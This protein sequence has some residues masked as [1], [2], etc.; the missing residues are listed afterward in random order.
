[1][2]WPDLSSPLGATAQLASHWL[3]EAPGLIFPTPRSQVLSLQ[4][5]VPR[6]V[7]T[8][9]FLACLPSSPSH[10]GSPSTRPYVRVL[11]LSARLGRAVTAATGM[12][13]EPVAGR[14][15]P[16][17]R[18]RL[19]CARASSAASPRPGGARGPG[20]PLRWPPASSRCGFQCL[21]SGR[22]QDL[23]G[24]RLPGGG[25][26]ECVLG[27]DVRGPSLAEDRETA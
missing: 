7:Q 20:L 27:C 26:P 25:P 23:D 21:L 4:D 24:C 5:F 14:L 15:A 6:A 2:Y 19:V 3:P 16:P 11:I 17:P 8:G 13:R 10:P 18:G 1:M 12:D 9:T 22:H